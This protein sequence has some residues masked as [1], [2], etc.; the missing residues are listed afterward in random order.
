MTFNYR[1]TSCLIKANFFWRVLLAASGP[2]CCSSIPACQRSLRCFLDEFMQ[3]AHSIY[4]ECTVPGIAVHINRH[5]KTNERSNFGEC[6][7]STPKYIAERM[8]NIL[9]NKLY[10][11]CTY[12]ME[13]SKSGRGNCRENVRTRDVARV[14][15]NTFG[16]AKPLRFVKVPS[17]RLLAIVAV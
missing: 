6:V 13:K 4:A 17:M 9:S 3:L 15:R 1:L 11:L 10:N 2:S 14:E 16:N 5:K 12:A 7:R 8:R